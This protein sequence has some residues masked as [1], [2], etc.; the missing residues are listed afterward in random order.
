MALIN[1]ATPTPP[2]FFLETCVYYGPYSYYPGAGG[3]YA[4]TSATG[5]S[6]F[7]LIRNGNTA[8]GR[9]ETALACLIYISFAPFFLYFHR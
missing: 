4:C 5:H 2:K 1:S 7:R 3:H 6:R 9:G 8:D